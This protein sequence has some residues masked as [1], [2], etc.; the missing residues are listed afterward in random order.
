MEIQIC[1]GNLQAFGFIADTNNNIVFQMEFVEITK[2]Q[3]F[4][5]CQ[6]QL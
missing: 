3:L 5:Y 4:L 2:L 6:L 1:F